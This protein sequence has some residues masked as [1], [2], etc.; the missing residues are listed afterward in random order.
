[1]LMGKVNLCC[2][3]P[4]TEPFPVLPQKPPLNPAT[5]VLRICLPRIRAFSPA[6]DWA[7]TFSHTPRYTLR[8]SSRNDIIRPT[9]SYT[10]RPKASNPIKIA[11]RWTA[12]SIQLELL[13]QSQ[14]VRLVRFV[15]QQ[16]AEPPTTAGDDWRRWRTR[17][18]SQSVNFRFFR[19]FR[20]LITSGAV[21]TACTARSPCAARR[22]DPSRTSWLAL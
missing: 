1:M 14:L 9:E 10:F 16:V 20:T 21:R 12:L 3:R 4:P 13:R 2:A 7:A 6:A 8:N 18:E 19:R 15:A 17:C 5:V 22:I 11:R